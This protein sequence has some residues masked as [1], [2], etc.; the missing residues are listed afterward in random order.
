MPSCLR[1]FVFSF[2]LLFFIICL[3]TL[4]S[5]YITTLSSVLFTC[6]DF[7]FKKICWSL[8]FKK[9]NFFSFSIDKSLCSLI[10]YL[11]LPSFLAFSFLIGT[12]LLVPV[13]VNSNSIYSIILILCSWFSLLFKFPC[14]SLLLL[15]EVGVHQ[16]THQVE[17]IKRN[18]YH[19]L[20][21]IALSGREGSA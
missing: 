10:L 9:N 21:I 18:I 8:C 13:V 2:Y 14:G 1:I 16:T 17:A 11:Y 4:V 7:R 15:P 12:S 20:K 3:F 5:F 6:V 19:S